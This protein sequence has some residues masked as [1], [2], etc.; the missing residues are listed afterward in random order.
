MNDQDLRI[1]CAELGRSAIVAQELYEFITK[2][3]PA[4][5]TIKKK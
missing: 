3:Q 1:K 2:K 4:K 5:K